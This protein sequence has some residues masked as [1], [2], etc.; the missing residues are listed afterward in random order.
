MIILIVGIWIEKGIGLIV[1]GLV[2][3]PMGELIDY[4]PS[5]VELMITLGVVSLGMFVITML[6]KPALIIEKKYEENHGHEAQ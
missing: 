6:L 2:P 3:S 1:P 5:G 4:S